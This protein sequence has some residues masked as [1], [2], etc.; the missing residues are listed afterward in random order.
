MFTEK[1]SRGALLKV[2]EKL[3]RFKSRKGALYFYS[4]GCAAASVQLALTCLLSGRRRISVRRMNA[5]V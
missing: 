4:G 5:V 1:L 3:L 2:C